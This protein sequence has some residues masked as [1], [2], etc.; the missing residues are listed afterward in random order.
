MFIYDRGFKNWPVEFINL[1]NEEKFTDT[2]II[3]SYRTLLPILIPTFFWVMLKN[4][5]LV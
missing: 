2:M 3:R 5:C 1:F 4:Q